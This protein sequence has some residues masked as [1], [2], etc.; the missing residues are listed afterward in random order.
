MSASDGIEVG[1]LSIMAEDTV[2][3]TRVS[4]MGAQLLTLSGSSLPVVGLFIDGFRVGSDSEQLPVE[5]RVVFAP[6]D[7]LTLAAQLETAAA[8][9]HRQEQD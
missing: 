3:S 4:V 2:Y 8:A 7:A 6:Q 5:L 1:Q 9:C